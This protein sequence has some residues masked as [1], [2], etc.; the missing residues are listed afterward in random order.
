MSLGQF[1][2]RL[3]IL[4]RLLYSISSLSSQVVLLLLKIGDLAKSLD[5]AFKRAPV[6][7]IAIVK[8]VSTP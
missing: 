2:I 1:D 7:N 4:E 6:L 8:T 3:S 5:Q